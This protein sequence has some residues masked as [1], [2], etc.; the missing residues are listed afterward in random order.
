G[1]GVFEPVVFDYAAAVP[2]SSRGEYEIPDAISAM[3][4]SGR[5]VHAFPLKG[6]WS[7][8]GTAEDLARAQEWLR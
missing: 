5:S 7:D 6:H 4:A 1:L 8:V 2:P 3:I